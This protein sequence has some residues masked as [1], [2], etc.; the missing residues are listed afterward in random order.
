MK[1][2]FTIELSDDDPDC[3]LTPYT[4]AQNRNNFLF[5]MSYNFW[6]QFK[7]KEEDTSWEEVKEKYFDL[8]YEHKVI[9]ED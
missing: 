2:T 3:L 7:H 4:N 9:I 1:K 6:R 8:L 5:E